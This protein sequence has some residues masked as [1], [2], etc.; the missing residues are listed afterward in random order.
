MDFQR[1]K[2]PTLRNVALTAPYLH[3]GSA[4][5]LEAATEAMFTFQTG[6]EVSKEE[7]DKLVLFMKTLTGENPMMSYVHPG[8]E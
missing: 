5:T 4:Q 1:F 3:D 8:L 6:K 2:T 7:I